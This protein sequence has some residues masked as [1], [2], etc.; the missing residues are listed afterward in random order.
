MRSANLPL[1][2][3]CVSK[4]ER[5][6]RECIGFTLLS[7]RCAQ[8]IPTNNQNNTEVQWKWYKLLGVPG[9]YKKSHPQ[10][11]LSLTLRDQIVGSNVFPALGSHTNVETE[12]TKT[13][14]P[15]HNAENGYVQVIRT[16]LRANFIRVV[17]VTP[18][19]WRHN[20]RLEEIP[21]DDDGEI[22]I[23]LRRAAAQGLGFYPLQ[24]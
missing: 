9:V 18:T 12:G 15:I 24:G 20:R 7:M 17:H 1:R 6:N 13:F 16:R 14:V 21:A 2:I 4:D 19:D 5:G 3:E 8:A 22:G 23:E 11:Q 10:L